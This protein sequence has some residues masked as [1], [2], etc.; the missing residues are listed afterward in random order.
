M[1]N[2]IES[3]GD[4]ISDGC[5]EEAGDQLMNA[6]LRCDGLSRPPEFVAGDAAPTLA[7]MILELIDSLSCE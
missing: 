1:R 4:L 2:Q 5:M 6:Y 3:A 7:S